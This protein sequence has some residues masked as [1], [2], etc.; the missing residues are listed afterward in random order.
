MQF[1]KSIARLW[2]RLITPPPPLKTGG[3]KGPRPHGAPDSQPESPGAEIC[4][5]WQGLEFCLSRSDHEGGGLTAALEQARGF[6][7]LSWAFLTVLRA[8]DKKHYYLAAA[9][10]NSP[11]G[12]AGKYPLSSGLAGWLHTKLKPLAIDR[13]KTDSQNSYI[14]QKNEPLR[15]FRSFYGWPILYNDQPRGALILAGAEGETLEHDLSEAMVCVV[16]RLAAQLHLDRLIAK[17]LEMDQMDTQTGLSYRGSFMESLRQLMRVADVKGEGAD[18]YVLAASGLGALAVSHGQGTAG[19][20]LKALAVRLKDGPRPTW[21]LGHI[22]HGVFTL[23]TPSADAAEARLFISRF[24]KSLENWPLPES[25]GRAGLG[26]FLSMASYPRDG[27]APEE[28]LE[29]A[30]TALAE[31][32]EGP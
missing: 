5:L 27:A 9:S 32:E 17:V 6:T 4:A 30:L 29:A 16:D 21:K 8:D 1:G 10:A 22:S 28:L 3:T 26:L 11:Q 2:R 23:A 19:D 12:L 20:L 14:F 25:A 7:G 15:G 13:L 24:K 31:S 18:L